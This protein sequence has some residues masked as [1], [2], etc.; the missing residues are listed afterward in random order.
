MLRLTLT[1]IAAR[2]R[3]LVGTCVA[4]LLGVAFLSGTLVLGDTLRGNF[5]S[6]FSTAYA[7]TDAQVRRTTDVNAGAGRPRGAFDN[8]VVAT[9]RS[10]PGV[11]TAAPQVEGYG[12]LVGKDGKAIGGNGPPTLASSWTTDSRLN[13][14][15]L[16][17]GRAPRTSNE[18]VINRGAAKDGDLHIGDT[19]TLQVPEPVRVRIVGVATF[20]DNEDGLGG[21]T[22]TAFTVK[23]AQEHLLGGKDEVTSIAVVGDGSV[24]QSELVR[25]ID[26]RLP[27]GLES[28]TGQALVRQATDDINQNFLDIFTT[29]LTVFAGVAL[30]VATFSIY[31][32]FSILVAQRAQE[33][34]LL[35]ALGASRA[36][37]LGSVVLEAAAVGVL[38]GAV[39]VA[40]GL[41]V[42]AGLLAMFHAFGMPLPGGG[43]TI[44]ASALLTAFFA[45]LI[46]TLVA[47]IAPAVRASRVRPLAAMRAAAV[48]TSGSS[49]GRLIGGGLTFLAGVAIVIA[50]VVGGG[51]G[52][53]GLAALGA[54]ATIVGFVLLGP[55]AARRATGVL[56]SPLPRFR[57]V[58]GSLAQRNAMRSPR[59]T[60]AT[61]TALMIGVGVVTIFTVFITSLSGTVDAT[62][63]K[64][65]TGDL[66]ISA[67][68]QGALAPG[69][70]DRIDRVPQVQ[71]AFGVGQDSVRMNGRKQMVSV[72]D[73][74]GLAAYTDLDVTSGRLADLGPD[75]VAVSNTEVDDHGLKMGA[76]VTVQLAD[77]SSKRLTV[78]A[79]YHRVTLVGDVIVPEAFMAPHEQQAIDSLV[80]ID[81]KPGVTVEQGRAA[82]DRVTGPFG[83]PDVL[84][85]DELAN[86]SA[87][88]LNMV[89]N[90]VYVMLA[91]AIV[92][93]L[94]G[95][96][97]TLALSLYERQREL[98]LLRA[99]GQSRRQLKSMVRLESG[100]VAVFGTLGGIALGTFL[101]WGLVSSL[102]TI[103]NTVLVIPYARL[104][105][106]LVVGAVAGLLAGIR[107]ARRAARL[108]PLDAIATP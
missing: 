78:G 39:G 34:A 91:L 102:P 68:F 43:L 71:S 86:D 13:Q 24:S 25:R 81:L 14:Y 15:K 54:V 90:I 12:R 51:G 67:G 66:A 53:I 58:T 80:L 93:A 1:S 72:A 45:G 60:S 79:V 75:Q 83:R 6:V 40:A 94:M 61:A 30:L 9:V 63:S 97:N 17:E 77:G 20:G 31:N 32:T 64:S 41:G 7:T 106:V 2:K 73:P 99:V 65:F 88:A 69:L 104:A 103:E 52:A 8:E 74:T 22:Y 23:G 10:V 101:G 55:V 29:F 35:R 84:T 62:T 5:N 28:V 11:E 38:A 47:G 49:L 56:G 50:A 89:L 42:S 85:A 37:L 82:I 70:A 18:V 48:D 36:Q 98:G 96:A 105:I 57:G 33:G 76:P 3:R 92:I 16:A 4:V 107:P 95:I 26:A 19:T 46:V 108:D 27:A 59:R 44:H 87:K 100:L 21:V